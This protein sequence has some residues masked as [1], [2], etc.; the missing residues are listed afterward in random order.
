ML[1]EILLVVLVLLGLF[2]A[3]IATR[4]GEFTITRS[5][6]MAATSSVPFGL[7]NDFHEWTHWSPWEH[8]DPNLQRTYE[9]P[10]SGEGAVYKWEG[11]RNVGQGMMKI[12]ESRP[13]D[14][15]RIHLE[16]I[17]PFKAV[18]TT[19]FEFK[20]SGGQTTVVWTMHGN[21]NFMGKAMT[22][23]MNMDKMIGGDFEKGLADMKAAA[24]KRASA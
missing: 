23:F 3:Y 18:N 15:I 22:V 5:S 13:N 2:A 19:D 8:R 24:E 4:P 21:N 6:T 12:L 7:I 9:G 20:E 17:K 10:A 14:V 16:F 11:D 1:T